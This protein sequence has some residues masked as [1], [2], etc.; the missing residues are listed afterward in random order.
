MS[1][2]YFDGLDL[3]KLY[4]KELESPLLKL[5]KNPDVTTVIREPRQIYE[6]PIN[7]QQEMMNIQGI[8]YNPDAMQQKN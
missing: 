8:T 5:M 1:H 3:E 7:P 4:R 2:P 6:T